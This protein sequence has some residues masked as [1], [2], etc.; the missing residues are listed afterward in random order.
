MAGHGPQPDDPSVRV[1]RN[2]ASTAGV[3]DAVQ[4]RRSSLGATRHDGQPWHA[5]TRRWWQTVWRSAI[6]ERWVDA[7][8][9]GLLALARLVDDFWR[10]TSPVVARQLHAEIRMAEREFGLTP[11]AGRSMGWEFRRPAPAEE[12]SRPSLPAGADP[13]KVLSLESRRTG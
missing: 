2:R 8:V 12:R 13:R 9:P 10:E 4:A 7:H 11:M 1:R 6:A 3:I 5:H